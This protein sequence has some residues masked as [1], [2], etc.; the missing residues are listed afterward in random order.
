MRWMTQEQ[1]KVY[2]FIVAQIDSEGFPPT[3]QEIAEATAAKPSLAHRRVVA[4]EKKGYL[5]REGHRATRNIRIKIR[6]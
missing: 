6:L 1:E 3:I 2:R 4:L 5:A